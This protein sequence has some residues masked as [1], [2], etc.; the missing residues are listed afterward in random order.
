MRHDY[1]VTLL[2]RFFSLGKVLL[3]HT[4]NLHSIQM[5]NAIPDARSARCLF[6]SP[7]RHLFLSRN[8]FTVNYNIARFNEPFLSVVAVVFIYLFFRLFFFLF[9]LL[10]FM[11]RHREYGYIFI[12]ANLCNRLRILV[13]VENLKLESPNG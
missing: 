11:H 1:F 12:I 2:A 10:E 5:S 7:E 13:F 8:D 3:A 6:T 4:Y 9:W